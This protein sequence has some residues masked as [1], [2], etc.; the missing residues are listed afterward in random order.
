MGAC[1]SKPK[2]LKDEDSAAP[3]PEPA[4]KAESLQPAADQQTTEEVVENKANEFEETE[5]HS[6]RYL[7]DNGE[8]LEEPK[9]EEAIVEAEVK[10]EKAEAKVETE[11]KEEKAEAKVETQ[12]KEEKTMAEAEKKEEEE[13]E[14]AKVVAEVKKDEAKEE[15][16]KEEAKTEAAIVSKGE[17]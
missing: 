17:R 3:K 2:V 11:R 6:F 13:E 15:A 10:E 14:E 1:T 12:K 16:K 7:L 4:A 9:E 8:K 5:P